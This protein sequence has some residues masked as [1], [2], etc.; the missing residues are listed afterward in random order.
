MNTKPVL[1]VPIYLSTNTRL[2]KDVLDE[3]PPKTRQ[4][5]EV[6]VQ[7]KKIQEIAAMLQ[8]AAH[9]SKEEM[10]KSDGSNNQLHTA[11]QIS[12][13]IKKL[14]I[15]V[16]NSNISSLSDWNGE[17]S[18]KSALQLFNMA[19]LKTGLAKIDGVV[20]FCADLIEQKIKFLYFA[21]HISM[22]DGMSKY[23]EKKKVKFI[24]IDGRVPA[25]KR[26]EYVGRKSVYIFKLIFY[27]L[28]PCLN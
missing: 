10:E 20:E 21:H 15:R 22:L 23:L 5:I 19:Y 7:K 9:K 17:M 18:E 13:I 16:D 3:L 1:K 14:N 6:K 11:G 28:R 8:L 26:H 27:R 24:R 4:K 2:K 12:G 25:K